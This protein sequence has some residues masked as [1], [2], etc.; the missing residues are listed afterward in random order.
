MEVLLPLR[1]P[2]TLKHRSMFTI[3]TSVLGDS[4]SGLALTTVPSASKY[5]S[6]V[7]HQN[8]VLYRYICIAR[9][10]RWHSW[11]T[12]HGNC[13]PMESNRIYV[14]FEFT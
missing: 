8:L 5:H 1:M 7:G 11:L 13:I 4:K 10:H 6:R 9:T 3:G 14:L 12:E 2:V